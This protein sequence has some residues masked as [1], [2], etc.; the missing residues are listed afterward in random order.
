LVF[1]PPGYFGIT[2]SGESKHAIS[3]SLVE[4]GWSDFRNVGVGFLLLV[5][6][7]N[8]NDCGKRIYGSAARTE[9]LLQDAGNCPS[10]A[11]YG[12]FI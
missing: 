9:V 2:P 3:A 8:A 6:A 10:Q 11:G 1:L 5:K 4:I 7:V 12:L